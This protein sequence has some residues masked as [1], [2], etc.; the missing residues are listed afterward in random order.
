MAMLLQLVIATTLSRSSQDLWSHTDIVQ[1]SL[2]LVSSSIKKTP[3]L[4][5]SQQ[6]A[7]LFSFG[8]YVMLNLMLNIIYILKSS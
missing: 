1:G 2:N 3:H 5:N 7:P 8:K 4:L 6:L